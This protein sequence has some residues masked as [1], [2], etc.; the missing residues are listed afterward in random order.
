MLLNVIKYLDDRHRS[1][2]VI[3]LILVGSLQQVQVIMYSHFLFV[4][5]PFFDPDRAI[6]DPYTLEFLGLLEGV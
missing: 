5:A 3:S 4:T 6:Y 2:I 1:Y